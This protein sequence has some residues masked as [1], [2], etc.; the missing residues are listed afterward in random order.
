MRATP[1]IIL[2]NEWYYL[3]FS[4][5]CYLHTMYSVHRVYIVQCILY[6]VNCY[7]H[8]MYSVYYTVY[9]VKCTLYTIH[10]IMYSVSFLFNEPT[11]QYTPLVTCYLIS[12]SVHYT[13]YYIKPLT[14]HRQSH[15]RKTKV[16]LWEVK[17]VEHHYQT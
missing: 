12:D 6:S 5:N 17:S 3:I 8:T 10:C 1:T 9:S 16:Q 11:A 13:L 2:E 7:L 15:H 4:L 14:L